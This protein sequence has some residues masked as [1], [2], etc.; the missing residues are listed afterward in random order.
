MRYLQEGFSG[1][2]ASKSALKH[3]LIVLAK[4]HLVSNSQE[5]PTS[6]TKCITR[7]MLAC[8][9]ATM[10]TV[11]LTFGLGPAAKGKCQAVT[12]IHLKEVRK[13]QILESKKRGR[14]VEISAS[15]DLAE[16]KKPEE[17]SELLSPVAGKL[18]SCLRGGGHP[19]LTAGLL[20][21]PCSLQPG[22]WDNRHK[23]AIQLPWEE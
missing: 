13:L 6:D 5:P 12:Y 20:S 1:A 10:T 7:W 16:N 22:T 8:G 19:L 4:A 23:V 14:C 2:S 18:Y 9:N 15:G 3:S 11:Q 21:S 17:P